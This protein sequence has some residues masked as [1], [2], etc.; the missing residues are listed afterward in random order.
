MKFFDWILFVSFILLLV[1][2]GVFFGALVVSLVQ[3]LG[4][5]DVRALGLSG[6]IIWAY[7]AL[8]AEIWAIGTGKKKL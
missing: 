7:I 1:A 5:W 6:V 4:I 3:N 8:L 2:L